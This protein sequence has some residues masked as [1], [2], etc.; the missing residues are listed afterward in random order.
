[1]NWTKEK[2]KLKEKTDNENYKKLLD[3]LKIPIIQQEREVN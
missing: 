2:A 1:M 3:E